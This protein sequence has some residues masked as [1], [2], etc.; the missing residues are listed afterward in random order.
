[1]RRSAARVWRHRRHGI[2]TREFRAVTAT[3]RRWERWP[4]PIATATR[5]RERRPGSIATPTRRREEWATRADWRW[6]TGF[7]HLQFH[8]QVAEEFCQV[9]PDNFL[10]LL[11]QILE[12]RFLGPF[13]CVLVGVMVAVRVQLGAQDGHLLWVCAQVFCDVPELAEL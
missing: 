6:G 2:T 5:R 9:R 11:F 4:G 13:Q 10:Q 1:R 8:A 7:G 12:L 3:A